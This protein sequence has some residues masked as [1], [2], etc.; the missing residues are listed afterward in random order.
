MGQQQSQE[1]PSSSTQIPGKAPVIAGP[2]AATTKVKPSEQSSTERAN[3][4]YVVA[5]KL[6][7]KEKE[8]GKARD[9]AWRA[10]EYDH[11]KTKKLEYQTKEIGSES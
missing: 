3:E 4:R 6:I 8:I 10:L 7:E 9:I 5:L 2:A 1:K 11:L